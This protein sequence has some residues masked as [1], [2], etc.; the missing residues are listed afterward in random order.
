MPYALQREDGKYVTP[1]GSKSS[2]V[3]GIENARAFDTLDAAK[4][5]MCGNERIVQFGYIGSVREEINMRKNPRKRTAIKRGDPRSKISRASVARLQ[6]KH[7]RSNPV[8]GVAI[9]TKYI[10]PTNVRGARVKAYTESGRSITLGWN[11][12]LNSEENHEGAAKALAKKMNWTGTLIGGGTKTGYAF[13]FERGPFG[14][15]LHTTMR[16]NPQPVH[17]KRFVLALKT[18]RGWSEIRKSY[19]SLIAAKK[20]ARALAQGIR[21]TV[22]ITAG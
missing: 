8:T 15:N 7:Y 22:R 2:Y 18:P 19:A 17:R 9:L 12:A 16:R 14:K 20:A 4:R 13:V 21:A 5:D 6:A 1:L 11:H 3:R 10:G